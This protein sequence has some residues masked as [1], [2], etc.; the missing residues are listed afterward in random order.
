MLQLTAAIFENNTV[1]I[2]GVILG[3]LLLSCQSIEN[4]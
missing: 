4:A 3:L 2:K 1:K